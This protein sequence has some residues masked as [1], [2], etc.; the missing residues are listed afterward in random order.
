MFNVSKEKIQAQ[1]FN[2]INR[3]N[4]IISTLFC[5]FNTSCFSKQFE[6]IK[7][8]LRKNYVVVCVFVAN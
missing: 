2:D 3:L 6:K 8:L 5:H 7:K 4:E 1:V